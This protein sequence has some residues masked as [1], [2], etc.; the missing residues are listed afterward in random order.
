ME[1]RSAPNNFSKYF[2]CKKIKDK[3]RSRL[4]QAEY[5][6]ILNAR[7]SAGEFLD[8]ALR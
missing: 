2:H 4:Q 3:Y 8:N 5:V 6:Y 7:N 1:L